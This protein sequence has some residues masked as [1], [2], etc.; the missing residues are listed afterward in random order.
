MNY[1]KKR[2]FRTKHQTTSLEGVM[3]PQN[4]DNLQRNRVCA[5]FVGGRL[6][7]ISMFGQK[8]KALNH[9]FG[10]SSNFI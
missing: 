3:R 7:K 5:R 1:I 9:L 8:W 4:S 6:F 10:D 2:F